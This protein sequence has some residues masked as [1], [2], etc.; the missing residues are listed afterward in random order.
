M[1]MFSLQCIV[2][3]FIVTFLLY[4]CFLSVWLSVMRKCFL[5]LCVFVAFYKKACEENL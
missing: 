5:F 2:L 1:Y 4:I 3:Q